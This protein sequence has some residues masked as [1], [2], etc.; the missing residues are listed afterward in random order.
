M[1]LLDNLSPYFISGSHQP[2]LTFPATQEI[3]KF[4]K[5]MPLPPLSMSLASIV[6]QI[7]SCDLTL[8]FVSLFEEDVTK[9]NPTASSEET[10]L[11]SGGMSIYMSYVA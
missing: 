8:I 9:E 6:L 4:K 11:S 10:M 1:H 5:E 3:S 7:P 2:F